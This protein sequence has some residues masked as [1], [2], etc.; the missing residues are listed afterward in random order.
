MTLKNVGTVNVTV[1]GIRMEEA[2][3]SQKKKNWD[4]DISLQ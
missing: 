3:S 4:E 1:E 2:E